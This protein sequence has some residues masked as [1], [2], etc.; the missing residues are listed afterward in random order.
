M[1]AIFISL[2]LLITVSVT[3]AQPVNVDSL[4]KQ[5]TVASDD[6]IKL[7]VVAALIHYYQNYKPDSGL[8]YA[9]QMFNLA[10]KSGNRYYEAVALSEV[11]NALGHLGSYTKALEMELK[12]LHVA[13]QLKERR[14]EQ[15]GFAY[16]QIGILDQ[17]NG[18]YAN[19]IANFQ[20]CIRYRKMD[21]KL[22]Q[23]IYGNF[24]KLGRR[25]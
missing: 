25:G 15:M 10:Q 4:K 2:A 7:K 20:K 18:R 11:G 1:K 22:E 24:L 12:S 3:L 17:A 6:S 14:E 23:D 13:E 19:A 21:G 5:L 9:R 16:L 8:H